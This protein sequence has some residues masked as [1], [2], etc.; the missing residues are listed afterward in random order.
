MTGA[1]Y[2]VMDSELMATSNGLCDQGFG[3]CK[4]VANFSADTTSA[5]GSTRCHYA[6]MFWLHCAA[7]M[8][9]T[10]VPL[11]STYWQFVQGVFAWQRRLWFLC[12]LHWLCMA[13]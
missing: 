12:T 1:M 2:C 10:F 13:V 9:Q 6:D 11:K 4:H 3:L 7:G 5:I 8:K